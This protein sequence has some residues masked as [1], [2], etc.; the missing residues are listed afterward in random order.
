MPYEDN[1]SMNNERRIFLYSKAS[2][3]PAPIK[4]KIVSIYRKKE[5]EKEFVF[6]NEHLM[7]HDLFRN[8]LDHTRTLGKYQ[9]PN[10]VNITGM[11]PNL[12][13]DPSHPKEL[14]PSV[15]SSQI[16]STSTVYEF[17]WSKTKPQLLQWR[18]DGLIDDNCQ[19][20]AWV[21]TR[22]YSV[23]SW[24][25]FINLRIEDL[26]LLNRTNIDSTGLGLDSKEILAMAREKAR[27]KLTKSVGEEVRGVR[28]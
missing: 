10:I 28:R 11:D 8:P 22:K 7:T 4:H 26:V 1:P 12:D 27:E 17:E 24:D 21:G 13:Y 16:E 2:K 6:F 18:T 15:L 5:G 9:L 25:S 14:G 3:P 20:I 19:F 23:S